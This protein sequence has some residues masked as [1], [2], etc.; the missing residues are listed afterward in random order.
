MDWERRAYGGFGL[1][2]G[3]VREQGDVDVLEDLA[4]S[5]AENTVG[6]FD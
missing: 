3:F 4:R 6:G 5:D 1:L 2:R